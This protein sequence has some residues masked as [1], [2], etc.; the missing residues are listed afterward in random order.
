MTD[1]NQTYFQQVRASG[2]M[3]GFLGLLLGVTAGALTGVA[4]KGLI[5]EP[6]VS[7][8]GALMFYAAFGI[9][10]LMTMF[11][12][13][14]YL[15]M[16]LLVTGEKFDIRLGMKSAVIDLADISAVR[17]AEPQSRMTRAAAQSRPDRRSIA[18]L[19]SVLGVKTGIEI[20]IR[21]GDD[22]VV[23]WFVASLDAEALSEKLGAVIPS[24]AS[25]E[26]SEDS[27]SSSGA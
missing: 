25:D 7:G 15:S 13:L 16:G 4:I 2:R 18:K 3:F 5:D 6:V 12:M 21:S 22:S 10:S 23:T 26:S 14:N 19:W 17:I 1:Q 20:D 9:S 27:D 8:S 11:V 24:N